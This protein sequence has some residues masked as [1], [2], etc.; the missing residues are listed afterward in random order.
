M[1]ST[2]S[3][4]DADLRT[5]LG[6]SAKTAQRL[7]S[8]GIVTVRGLLEHYP[9]RYLDRG[10]LKPIREARSGEVLTI[11]GTVKTA[12]R[13]Q[14]RRGLRLLEVRIYDG[15]GYV[16]CTWFN[17]DWRAGDFTPGT[18]VAVS[19]KLE[20]RYARLQM[21]NPDYEIL[22]E[23]DDP[24]SFA[25][26]ILPIY[27]ASAE[28]T[29]GLIRKAV[30]RALSTVGRIADPIPP[31]V[32]AREGL[33]DLDAALRGIHFPADLLV[34]L[35]ARDRLVFDELFFLQLGLAVRRM[36]L[37][38]QGQGLSHQ[39]DGPITRAFLERL[40][41]EPTRAQRAAMDEIG[42]D[43]ARPKPMHRLL[44]GEVGSGKTV[45]AV[46]ALLA[47]VQSGRQGAFMAPTEILALQHYR[48]VLGLL[49]EGG[50]LLDGP[51]VS[52]LTGSTKE[53]A[54]VLQ[55]VASG[56]T[57]IVVGT[58]A[59]IQEDVAFKSLGVAVVDEQH[60]FGVEQRLQLRRKGGS[61]DLLIMTAT[62]IPR[63]LAL[64]LYGDLDVSVLDELP[65]GRHPVRTEVV[66][67]LEGRGR[68]YD[69]VRAE[70]AA[71]R[72]VFVICALVDESDK[73]AAK[74]ARAEARRLAA[75]VF[76]ELRVGQIDGQMDDRVKDETMQEFRA[77]RLDLL[78]ST[79][80]IEVGVDVPNA[81]VMLVEDAERFGL[82]QLHQLRGRVGR[83]SAASHFICFANPQSPEAQARME[84][85]ASTD[86]GFRLAEM[87]L[88]LRGEGTVFGTAQSGL[89]DLKLARVVRDFEWVL[90]ARDA[91][92]SLARLDPELSRAEHAGLRAEIG[93]R[94]SEQQVEWLFQG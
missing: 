66:T 38:A 43:L 59:L 5:A 33:P 94:F 40:P 82:S 31:E 21:A 76:P 7:G 91:A 17:Q 25:G 89:P 28:T 73:L 49:G 90:R 75:E 24:S 62:P 56:H 60:R 61:P 44:Q 26:T 22:K 64:T 16:V 45:V 52:L 34:R 3:R 47:A 18:E 58:H 9:R 37:E 68:A 69:L 57:D 65:P 93:R 2:G 32:R 30:A 81:T 6:L 12:H 27:P 53:R 74:S 50:G 54:R 46:W 48:N 79:T 51:R 63:T 42:V 41:F 14:P 35:A 4:L 72:Q 15:T 67:D 88:D 36:R 39:V 19:G 13:R 78:I 87:D 1:I 8:L 55:E 83:G 92:W 77:G 71:G 20:W 11:A 10:E 85:I 29:T 86:D 70:A 80:V 23:D 84:A